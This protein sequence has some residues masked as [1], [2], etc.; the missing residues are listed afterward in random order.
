MPWR[1]NGTCSKVCH[2]KYVLLQY[3]SDCN[4]Q[5]CIYIYI[6]IAYALTVALQCKLWQATGIDHPLQAMAPP[7]LIQ[8]NETMYASKRRDVVPLNA[9]RKKTYGDV[10][11]SPAILQCSLLRGQNPQ[12]KI[13]LRTMI[14]AV[15]RHAIQR[16]AVQRH[17][18]HCHAMCFD[19]AMYGRLT[20]FLRHDATGHGDRPVMKTE[21]VQCCTIMS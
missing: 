4:R 3:A 11:M 12:L 15:Q 10:T 20:T 2:K 5:T 1:D 21:S 18:M 17:A 19:H 14:Y 6:D 7:C 9:S 13:W 8:T 16:H